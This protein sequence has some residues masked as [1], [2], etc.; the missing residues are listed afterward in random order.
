[1]LPAFDINGNVSLILDVDSDELAAFDET[2]QK[3]LEQIMRIIEK[4]T[5]EK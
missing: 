5:T 3:Y 1:V 2:D 4:V